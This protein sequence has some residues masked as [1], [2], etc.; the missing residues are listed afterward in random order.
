VAILDEVDP[1]WHLRTSTNPHFETLVASREWLPRL[2]D[3]QTEAELRQAADAL[4]RLGPSGFQLLMRA[5]IHQVQTGSPKIRAARA[6]LLVQFAQQEPE[7]AA[8]LIGLLRDEDA[9]VRQSAVGLLGDLDEASLQAIG[10]NA[11]QQLAKE[12]ASGGNE[13]LRPLLVYLK[14]EDRKVRTVVAEAL[15][16]PLARLMVDKDAAVRQSAVRLLADLDE[17]SLRA[18]SRNAGQYLAKEASPKGEG[19][20]TPLFVYLRHKDP[21]VRTVVAEA[22]LQ[23]GPQAVIALKE[24][25][26]RE[27][28]LS[29]PGVSTNLLES[30]EDEAESVALLA[31]KVLAESPPENLAQLAERLVAAD[32]VT[33]KSIF[34]A[35]QQAEPSLPSRVYQAQFALALQAR[36]ARDAA[37]VARFFDA[38]PAELRGVEWHCL[39]AGEPIRK[40]APQGYSH[41]ALDPVA[42]PGLDVAALDPASREKVQE[43]TSRVRSRHVGS[44]MALSPDGQR[45]AAAG[46]GIVTV[47]NLPEGRLLFELVDPMI[48]TIR[49]FGAPAPTDLRDYALAFSPDGARIAAAGGGYSISGEG[50]EAQAVNV[51]DARTGQHLLA[52]GGDPGSVTSIAFSPDGR[53]IATGCADAMVRVWHATNGQELLALDGA[54]H[55]PFYESRIAISPEGN[56]IVFVGWDGTT[57]IWGERPGS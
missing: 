6:G 32:P 40:L 33:R 16:A 46:G 15:P 53:R 17:A 14:H 50:R 19:L 20:F 29:G 2:R 22:L 34:R 38:C 25:F 18:I 23:T 10:R 30:L 21:K 47:W 56:R 35:L 7:A 12:I 4:M 24:H 31:A 41:A 3:A 51:W 9:A 27:A 44:K 26:E 36:E 45:I 8:P 52:F 54:P 42:G 13:L 28:T 39:K 11:G 1:Y 55:S 43:I 37:L 5:V 57:V 49:S 48:Q